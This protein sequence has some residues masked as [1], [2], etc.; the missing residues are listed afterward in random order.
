LPLG[1]W[2]YNSPVMH[3]A[4]MLLAFPRDH[5]ASIQY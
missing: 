4:E 1:F 5:G 3:T 2:Q